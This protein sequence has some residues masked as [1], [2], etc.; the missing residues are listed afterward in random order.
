[1]FSR[2]FVRGGFLGRYWGVK[3]DKI[4]HQLM[5][6]ILKL[7]KQ[8][9][10]STPL[11]K[12]DTFDNDADADQDDCILTRLTTYTSR[13]PTP[14]ILSLITSSD[15]TARMTTMGATTISTVKPPVSVAATVLAEEDRKSVV[16][17]GSC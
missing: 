2:G 10:A 9:V 7:E 12:G 8:L 6:A 5:V 1:M 4:A 11:A 3:I 17:S 13:T 14:T 15:A 16:S